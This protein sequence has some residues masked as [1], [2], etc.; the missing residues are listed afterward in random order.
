MGNWPAGGCDIRRAFQPQNL[1]FT[2]T[3]C[4]GSLS[5]HSLRLSSSPINGISLLDFAR[6]ENIFHQ[7][8]SGDCYLDWVIKD[9]SAYDN[10]YFDIS[11]VKVFSS[12]PSAT[13]LSSGGNGTPT[14]SGQPATT[15]N[16]ADR[17]K[18]AL[19]S[20]PMAMSAFFALFM[21]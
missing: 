5:A 21:S 10:A 1:V 13:T 17:V 6:P 14:Q 16:G 11:Y 19:L 9:P 7:T 8:C 12:N 2:V 15:G 20:A 4:G 18:A 3:L